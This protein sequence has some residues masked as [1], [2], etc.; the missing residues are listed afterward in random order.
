ICMI[1]ANIGSTYAQQIKGIV[2]DLENSQR[3]NEVQIKNLRTNQ[4]TL[5][6]NQGN[7][8]IDG[9]KNDYIS[10]TI[11]GYDRDT[12]FIYEDGISR[13]F[14]IRDKSNILID[15]VVVSKIT[16]SRINREIE[17]AKN[18]SKAVETSQ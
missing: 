11:R 14:L 8:T 15:E 5:T 2:F 13:I 6:D 4:V 17:K 1:S 9:Q 12:A 7:F 18:N 3:I 10:L 16:D